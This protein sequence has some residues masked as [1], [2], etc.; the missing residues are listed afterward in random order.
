MDIRAV[1]ALFADLPDVE[2]VSWVERGW[3]HPD[4]AESGFVFREI[5][6]A[7]VHLIHDL[8]R[9]ME[10]PEDTMTLVLSLLDQV[11]DLRSRLRT[12]LRAVEQQ[13]Q[14][15]RDALRAALER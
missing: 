6:V 2:L 9:D 11:Y 7:R 12:V 5:D 14:D 3:V 10:V 15:I 13:P 4:S 1:T 8:R